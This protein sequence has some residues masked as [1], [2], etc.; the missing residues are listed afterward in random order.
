VQATVG[1]VGS[2]THFERGWTKAMVKQLLGE[3]DKLVPNARYSSAPPVRLFRIE[4]MFQVEATPEFTAAI[5]KASRR[6][7]SGKKASAT[8]LANAEA[9]LRK[10]E[11]GNRAVAWA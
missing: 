5:E 9:W 10:V 1:F 8:R 4:R 7:E 6:I 3:P 2:G 11:G